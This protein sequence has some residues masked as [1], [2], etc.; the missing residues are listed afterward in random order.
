M[1]RRR[2]TFRQR[3]LT[4]ALKGALAAGCMVASVGVSQNGTIVVVVRKGDELAP[5]E[6]Q[7]TKPDFNE[8]DNP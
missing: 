8:W 2:T 3:D 7:D 1:S 6:A 5:F 4:A